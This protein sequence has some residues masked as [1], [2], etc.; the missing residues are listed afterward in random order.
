MKNVTKFLLLFLTGIILNGTLYSQIKGE[1]EMDEMWGDD[2]VKTDALKEGKGKLFDEGNYGMF[3]HW[4][5]FSN[6]GGIWEDKTYYGIGEWIMNPRVA[7]IP[8]KEYMETAKNFNPVDFDAKKIAKLAKDA[9]MKYII[10]TSKHHEGFAMFD[11]KVSDFDIVDATPFARDPMNELA[12]AC[13]ELGLGFGFYY[14][15]NQDWTAPGGGNGPSVDENGNE[16]SFKDYFYNKCKPQ[17]KEICS[18]YGEIDFVWFD[19]PGDMPKE[20]V[21]ELADMVREL[22]PNAMMCSRVGYGMGDYAS[23]GD[24]EVPTQNIPGL[25]ETADTNNDSWS[26]AWYDNN[27]KSPKMI[28]S[29]L[30]ETVGRGGTYLF[31]V[32]PDSKG[33]IP[34][35]G[36]EFLEES[37]TWLKKYPQVVYAAGPSP[38]G[39]K[40]PWGDVTTKDKSLFLSVFD[41][42]TDGKLYLPGLENE[43][44]SVVLLKGNTSVPITYTKEKDWLVFNTPYEA[45]EALI[46]VIEVK[47][48]NKAEDVVVN[49]PIGVYPNSDTVLLSEFSEVRNAE[50]KSI[51]WMEKFGEWKHVNQVSN[52]EAN[53]T[54]TWEVNVQNPGYYY[55]ELCYS[56]EG[57]LVWKTVTDE[58][59]MVQNQQAATEKYIFYN[60]GILEFKTPG[61]HTITVSLV[62]GD[63]ETSSLKSLALKPIH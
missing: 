47:L 7:N 11:S 50:E 46:S 43:I 27:F 12:D 13:H 57:R 24:M 10:I 53:G 9:G 29:R 19:T 60:M 33:A 59:V 6:L 44:E 36:I 31:N 3:I 34:E 63:K 4:G 45:P 40:L 30:I 18:N 51:K 49:S 22:Q 21:V 2:Q 25:W 54:V 1:K 62:E 56:G 58:G 16:T 39:H 48:K 52:W 61:K 17:V 32:G 35:I 26:Y 23:K 42:P 37:G 20:Y 38:W 14:S 55:L 5:L 15:H 28:L 8:P 41:W